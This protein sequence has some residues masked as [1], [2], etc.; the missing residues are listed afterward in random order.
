MGWEIKNIVIVLLIVSPVFSYASDRKPKVNDLVGSF[1]IKLDE[2]RRDCLGVELIQNEVN[3]KV[4]AVK[5]VVDGNKI[6][7]QLSD[8]IRHR[9]SDRI[10][11]LQELKR[12]VEEDYA[13]SYG[14]SYFVVT[15][16]YY[17]LHTAHLKFDLSE[18][19]SVDQHP[20]CNLPLNSVKYD[21]RFKANIDSGLSCELRSQKSK[22][23]ARGLG[24]NT[25]EAMYKNLKKN[26]R[27][28]WQYFGST[29][30]ITTTFPSRPVKD[31]G[32]YDNRLRPWYVM[33]AS[34]S[35]KN[36]VIVLD[37]SS[38]MA[39]SITL[40][41]NRTTRLEVAKDAVT[42]LLNALSPED[43]VGVVLFNTKAN[44]PG[45]VGED[46]C[47]QKGLARATSFNLKHLASFVSEAKPGGG[48]NYERS[49]DAAFSLL[50]KSVDKE[51]GD[52]RRQSVILF[53]T[54][55]APKDLSDPIFQSI[56]THQDK[57][58][59]DNTRVLILTYGIGKDHEMTK[60]LKRLSKE[61]TPTVFKPVENIANLHAK[62]ST[63]YE[64]L[65]GAKITSVKT[66]TSVSSP[67]LDAW[68]LG[69]LITVAIP[70][71][72]DGVLKGVAGTDITL[73][74]LLSDVQY[75][76]HAG[77]DSYSFMAHLHNGIVLSHPLMPPPGAITEDP[78]LIDIFKLEQGQAFKRFFG[79]LRNLQGKEVRSKEIQ[80]QRISFTRDGGSRQGISEMKVNYHYHCSRVMMYVICIAIADKDKTVTV[81]DTNGGKVAYH[82]MDLVPHGQ[83]CYY[84][85]SVSYRDKSTI[86]FSPRAFNDPSEYLDS[87]ETPSKITSYMNDLIHKH[88]KTFP[89]GIAETAKIGVSLE[90][91]WVHSHHKKCLAQIPRRFFGTINGVLKFFPGEPLPQ[92][93]DHSNRHWFLKAKNSPNQL[94]FTTPY[95]DPLGAGIIM[96]ISQSVTM[97]ISNPNQDNLFGVVAA[98]LTISN[99]DILIK[100]ELG[101]RCQD[102]RTTTCFLVDT[103]GYVVFH[104]RFAKRNLYDDVAIVTNKHITEIHG[105]IASYFIKIGAMK[106]KTCQDFS[107]RNMQIFYELDVGADDIIYN[108]QETP[109]RCDMFAMTRIPQ[110]NVFLVASFATSQSSC[111]DS[112][113]C[114][115]EKTCST[116]STCEC[117]CTKYLDY[118]YCNDVIKNELIPSCSPPSAKVLSRP[119]LPSNTAD[120][121][122]CFNPKCDEIES[123]SSCRKTFGCSWCKWEESKERDIPFCSYDND[124]YGGVWNRKNPFIRELGPK[125]TQVDPTDQTTTWLSTKNMPALI[126][127]VVSFL[128]LILLMSVCIY[129]CCCGKK[130]KEKPTEMDAQVMEGYYPGV[131]MDEAIY[132]QEYQA[133]YNYGQEGYYEENEEYEP[134]EY[135]YDDEF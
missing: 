52:K 48:T 13:R 81:Q 70:C 119:P 135:D 36:I 44:L 71:F 127:A 75:F 94:T 55:G 56:N 5:D 73:T 35:T 41:G 9:F 97:A 106:K 104:P 68:G 16:R 69:V 132:T 89:S 60:F 129:L 87:E 120:L 61:T 102:T 133:G 112:A 107:Q 28:K 7:K 90:K 21:P 72:R 31:C 115:C 113:S 101:F 10:T 32:Q 85:D 84:A 53:I 37:T 40:E 116:N 47:F 58:Y 111:Y 74:D 114:H 6:I 14:K 64:H 45:K 108:E 2:L 131:E 29:E 50:K 3:E 91:L 130:K 134:E 117:P 124:C 17:T 25:M 18:F 19:V 121:P 83:T 42:S 66:Y 20:C 88:R 30:G 39:A 51:R 67:Y 98:D 128:L 63:Y 95:Q 123:E 8:V 77:T 57:M 110:S 79:T 100:N 92:S 26:H 76:N 49:F 11:A 109:G 27:L 125:T 80:R 33:T 122:N 103:S 34:P 43:Q 12:G 23:S 65:E 59:A 82:R 99:F 4:K 78:A 24:D 93:Y 1:A 118:D 126:V 54:D 22:Q 105:H 15:N 96:S 62:L 38:S 86:K 46:D